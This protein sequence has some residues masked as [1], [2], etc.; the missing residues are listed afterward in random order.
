MS[1]IGIDYFISS[2]EMANIRGFVE[3]PGDFLGEL[4]DRMGLVGPDVE[5]FLV[6]VSISRRHGHER[7]DIVDVG[8]GA[9]LLAVA[10]NRHGLAVEQLI[11]ENADDVAILVGDIL[12]RAVDIVGAKN[13][14]VRPEHFVGRLKVQFER[15]FGYSVRVLRHG[16]QMF[17]H[18]QL[19]RS[20]DCDRR[21]EYEAFRFVRDGLI[22]KVDGAEEIG[23]VVKGAD[24]MGKAFRRV[25]PQVIHVVEWPISPERFDEGLVFEVA[26]DERA[27]LG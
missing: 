1:R 22:E 17:R 12:S 16:N 8:E 9:G 14:V 4:Q 5:G 10:E 25:S 11:H 26:F 27:V 13:N 19:V 23:F 7:S 6:G 24:E 20:V 3:G 15:V 21:S 2:I 18:R